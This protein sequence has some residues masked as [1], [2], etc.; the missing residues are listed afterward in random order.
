[1][2]ATID[3]L[4]GAINTGVAMA[5]LGALGVRVVGRVGDDRHGEKVAGLLEAVRPGLSAHLLRG[6]VGTGLT[7]ILE[8][9]GVD[10]TLLIATGANGQLGGGDICAALPPPRSPLHLHLGYPPLL[11]RF[12]GDEGAEAAVRLFGEVA[13]RGGSSSLDLCLPP[14]GA[15]EGLRWDAWLTRVLPHVDL[16]TPSFE[17]LLALLLPAEHARRVK[18]GGADAPD[19][20]TAESLAALVL[21]M[22]C[23]AVFLKL[24]TA[25]AI[26][27]TS[28]DPARLAPLART[29]WG[30]GGTELAQSWLGVQ[31]HA[32]IFAA[33]VGGTTGTG[34]CAIGGLLAALGRGDGPTAA[35]DAAVA[36]G[37]AAVEG[38]DATCAIPTWPELER[39]IAAGWERV[40][41]ASEWG[42]RRASRR[43]TSSAGDPVQPV[44]PMLAKKGGGEK[45]GS[46]WP[47]FLDLRA[48]HLA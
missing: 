38:E 7:T 28:S 42:A 17:E 36:V 48:L 27:A 25:G 4:G 34:D 19:R 6:A 20:E 16:L 5:R 15:A 10:R 37:A 9:A 14:P 11:S 31:L 1:M 44:L 33:T 23:G 2:T 39:R 12:S 21:Q 41:P 45:R 43:R 13:A 24:G 22:G 3:A 18:E 26:L 47:S 46:W 32:P 29:F 35:L 30:G 40:R 8:P